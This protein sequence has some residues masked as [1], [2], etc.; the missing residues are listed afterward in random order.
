V[1][2]GLLTETEVC[3]LARTLRRYLRNRNVTTDIPVVYS[4]EKPLKPHPDGPAASR[5][6]TGAHVRGR[7]RESLPSLPTLP[8]IFGL[9][10]ANHVIMELVKKV[11]G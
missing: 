4:T 8:A 2:L 11:Q 1:R 6:T 10:A 7:A 3:P 5:E 9:I